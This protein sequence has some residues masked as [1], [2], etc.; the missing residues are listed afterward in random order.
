MKESGLKRIVIFSPYPTTQE[1]LETFSR[2]YFGQD[3][4]LFNKDVRYH[5]FGSIGDSY[6]EKSQ[7]GLGGEI[8]VVYDQS[9]LPPEK[10]H[11]DSK[12]REYDLLKHLTAL[13]SESKRLCD[14][15]GIPYLDYKGQI[16][17]K[18]EG[19]LTI[20]F[21]RLKVRIYSRLEM[22]DFFKPQ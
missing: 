13:I 17:K 2:K 9:L 10:H 1:N 3:F 19:I 21:N 12:M 16:E 15:K 4:K 22:E 7:V 6:K 8:L 20:E 14:S 11:P 18:E 5:K